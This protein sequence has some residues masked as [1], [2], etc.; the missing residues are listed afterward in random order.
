M[1][2]TIILLVSLIGLGWNLYY[3][4][5]DLQ[6]HVVWWQ[7]LLACLGILGAIN[8]LHGSIRNLLKL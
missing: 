6:Q 5:L 7:I 2:W 1:F 4:V 3:L 8:G